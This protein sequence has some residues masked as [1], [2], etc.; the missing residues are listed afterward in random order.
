MF[1]FTVLLKR[2]RSQDR[3]ALSQVTAMQAGPRGPPRNRGPK[4]QQPTSSSRSNQRHGPASRR[5][6]RERKVEDEENQ[7]LFVSTSVDDKVL[8]NGETF[9]ETV[10]RLS[11]IRNMKVG[12]HMVNWCLSARTNDWHRLASAVANALKLHGM[13]VPG[14]QVYEFGI[15]DGHSMRSLWRTLLPFRNTTK[16]FMW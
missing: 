12:N 15:Y 9:Q 4:A 6:G 8:R 7:P 14:G 1:V 10:E 16:P 11:L 2:T 3:H 5:V 13:G